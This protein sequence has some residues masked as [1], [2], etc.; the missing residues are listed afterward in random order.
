MIQADM[1]DEEIRSALVAG[2]RSLIKDMVVDEDLNFVQKI[3]NLATI[4]NKRNFKFHID[5]DVTSKMV[6]ENAIN[7]S[8]SRS[9]EISE[10]NIM[11]KEGIPRN[12]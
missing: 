3:V 7:N 8:K 6:L 2:L 1:S 4:V 5:E 9:E 11:S 12:A 10:L